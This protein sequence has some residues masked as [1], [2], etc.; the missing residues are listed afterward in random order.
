MLIKQ[1][2]FALGMMAL[3]LGYS[4]YTIQKRKKAMPDASRRFFERTGYRY[5]DLAGQPLE[6]HIAYGEQLMKGAATKG[7]R[8]HM[9]RDFHGVAIHSVQQYT[10]ETGLTSTRTST[11]YTWTLPL[12]RPARFH[13]QI[14][15]KSLRGFAKGVKEA[16]SSGERVWH[17][18]YPYEVSTGDPQFDKRFNV[19]SD[20]PQAAAAALGAPHLRQMLLQCAEI[21][22]TVYPDQ[23]VFADPAQKNLTAAMGG[24]VG[25]MS[26]ATN[27]GKMMELTIPVHDHVAQVLATVF[28][29]CA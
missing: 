6:A 26:M 15:E 22:L 29:A 23:I 21:D 11:S 19:Y 1:L 3:F 14:A 16:F 18:Q 5:A 2:F 17:Q 7:Y 10:I 28:E 4:L 9:I 12:P 20:Q 27:P 8:I 24:M 13:L 25:T